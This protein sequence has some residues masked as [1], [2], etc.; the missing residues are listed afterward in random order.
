VTLTDWTLFCSAGCVIVSESTER[1]LK[2]SSLLP[3]G[4][5]EE[6]GRPGISEFDAERRV[7]YLDQFI[8]TQ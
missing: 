1:V 8:R 6:T 5:N 7:V 4:E 2:Q 3:V